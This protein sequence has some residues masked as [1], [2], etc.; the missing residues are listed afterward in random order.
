MVVKVGV[1]AHLLCIHPQSNQSGLGVAAGPVGPPTTHKV[2]DDR[3]WEYQV[4]EKLGHGGDGII[5]NM[6]DQPGHGIEQAVVAFVFS[7]ERVCRI[8]W[9]R[10]AP[11]WG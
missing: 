3:V 9:L 7:L 10:G 11:P 5:V 4:P 2:E 1:L 8:R 6:Y